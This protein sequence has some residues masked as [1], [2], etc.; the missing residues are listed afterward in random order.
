MALSMAFTL[1][2][3]NWRETANHAMKMHLLTAWLSA[4]AMRSSYMKLKQTHVKIALPTVLN[5][6]HLSAVRSATNYLSSRQMAAASSR[7]AHMGSTSIRR[8]KNACNVINH[9]EL[10]P[11]T[12]LSA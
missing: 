12:E 9:V 1:M 5:A 8:V 10:A 3:V 4:A 7:P 2:G 6:N 11:G